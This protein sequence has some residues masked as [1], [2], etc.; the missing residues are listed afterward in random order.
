MHEKL[1]R[2]KGIQG[3]LIFTRSSALDH[4][5]KKILMAGLRGH[6]DFTQDIEEAIEALHS[7]LRYFRSLENENDDDPSVTGPVNIND[8]LRGPIK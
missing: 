3:R 6:K 2:L 8:I 7:A 4:A 1:R 5:V